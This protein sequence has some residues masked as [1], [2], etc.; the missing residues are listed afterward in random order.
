MQISKRKLSIGLILGFLPITPLLFGSQLLELVR[1]DPPMRLVA[2]LSE[3]TMS[4]EENGEVVASYGIAIGRPS[5]I[6]R[7]SNAIA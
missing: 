2:D 3:R 1:P 5:G 4:V 6:S 7:F